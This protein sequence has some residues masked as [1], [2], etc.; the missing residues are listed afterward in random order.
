MSAARYG[1][2]TRD[3]SG[4]FL[5][6]TGAQLALVTLAG[7]PPDALAQWL[8]QARINARAVPG[9]ARLQRNA[10]GQWDGTLVLNLPPR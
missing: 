8:A 7:V 6:M 1:D 10:A 4:W 2:Y 9:E 5:G 3:V